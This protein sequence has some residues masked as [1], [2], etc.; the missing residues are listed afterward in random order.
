MRLVI[1]TK[2]VRDDKPLVAMMHL[3]VP[4]MIM[5]LTTLG[6]M[7]L[8]VALMVFIVLMMLA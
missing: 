5:V 7:T 3:I 8:L 1:S 4:T 2:L 6:A